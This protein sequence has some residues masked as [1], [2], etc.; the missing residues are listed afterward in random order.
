MA[1]WWRYWSSSIPTTSV[2]TTP[3]SHPLVKEAKAVAIR[4]H[5]VSMFRQ[6]LGDLRQPLAVH[7]HQNAISIDT[8]G[9]QQRLD[10]QR[11]QR[12]VA[13]LARHVPQV[14]PV[15]A[16]GQHAAALPRPH[17]CRLADH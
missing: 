15:A 8:A 7:I 2:S 13:Q 10:H 12:A 14:G 17:R 6:L 1:T 3:S 16:R 9:E 11:V 4:T 5:L